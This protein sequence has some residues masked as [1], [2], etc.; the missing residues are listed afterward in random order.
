MYFLPYLCRV[1]KNRRPALAIV[2]D[3]VWSLT[4]DLIYLRRHSFLSNNFD[5]LQEAYVVYFLWSRSCNCMVW[6]SEILVS[7]NAGQISLDDIIE[8]LKLKR[9]FFIQVEN[10]SNFGTSYPKNV[11]LALFKAEFNVLKLL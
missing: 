9:Q 6:W 7:Y 2:S 3:W 8:N 10:C 4:K 11:C 5:K 1:V